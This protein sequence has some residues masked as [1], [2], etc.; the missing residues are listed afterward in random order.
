MHEQTNEPLAELAP[1]SLDDVRAALGARDAD[2]LRLWARRDPAGFSECLSAL[3]EDESVVATELLG[4]ELTAD[5]VS[6]LYPEEAAEVLER[7]APADAADV[8][9]EMA[10]DDAADVVGE[11]DAAEAE[12]VL[13]EMAEEERT[14][15][16]ELLAYPPDTAGGRMTTEFVAVRPDW[17][18]AQAIAEIRRVADETET[19]HYVYVVDAD[20]RLMGVLSLRDLIRARSSQPV[21]RVM[22]PDVARARASDDQEQTARLLRERR[23]AALPVVDEG[24][25][26]LGIVTVDDVDDVVEEETTEDIE[27]LGGSQPLDE[28]YLRASVLSIVRKRA[29]WLAFLFVAQA[30]TSTV[31][32]HFQTELAAVIALGFFIPLLVGTGGNVGSQTVTTLIRAMGVGDVDWSDLRRVLWKELRVSVVLG[33]LLAVGALARA[34]MQG[35]DLDVGFVVAISAAFIVV[36]AGMVASILPLVLRRLGAD[37]A[38]VSAPMITTLV[39]GTGLFIYFEIARYL[40][41]L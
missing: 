28:P 19:V 12:T 8:L 5:V 10:P 14:E 15:L 23:F 39:D 27:R 29:V 34:S 11:L 4:D 6:E 40:L 9:E 18:V 17:N 22:V 35:V 41:R 25:R 26:L 16:R 31:I 3:D 32:G 38:V 37:P 2:R 20:Q 30:Y 13:G 36:W 24:D 1:L 33:V 7:L 21:T